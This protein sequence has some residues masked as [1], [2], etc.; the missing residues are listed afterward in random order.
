MLLISFN[1]CALPL[2]GETLKEILK[3]SSNVIQALLHPLVSQ[4]AALPHLVNLVSMLF[5]ESLFSD[6]CFLVEFLVL[7]LKVAETIF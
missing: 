1:L 4:L 6:S 5:N 3:P 2:F 7:I